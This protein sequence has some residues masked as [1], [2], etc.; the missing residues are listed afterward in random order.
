M[1]Y[2]GN[3][4]KGFTDFIYALKSLPKEI[5]ERFEVTIVGKGNM[6]NE[7]MGLCKG[8][9]NIIFI[10][11]M[12]HKEVIEALKF[13]DVVMLPSRYEGLSMFAL[14]GLATGNACLFSNTGGLIDMVDGNGFLFEPQNVESIAIALTELAN[15]DSDNLVNMK[16]KSI[17]ICEDKFSSRVVSEK[18]KVIFDIVAVGGK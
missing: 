3:N 9:G 14:E 17:K 2:L 15:L 12:P 10:E 7:L 11:E 13:S 5:L 16:K 4:Q 1:D 18:F 8:L 6:R